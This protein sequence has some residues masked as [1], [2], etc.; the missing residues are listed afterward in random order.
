MKR[1]FKYIAVALAMSLLA[2]G[3][4]PEVLVPEQDKLP[5]ASSLEVVIT[6]DQTTNFVTF[7]VKNAQGFV[8]MWIFGEDLIDGKANKKF[9]YVGNDIVLRIREAGVHKV[10]VKAYN[11]HGV[12]VGSK[13]ESY[14]LDN[15]Y[16]EL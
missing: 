1:F 2:I 14:Q 3:C 11:A 4:T 9:A 15:T 8:P 10:E 5:E 6:P 13:I 12:S 16:R 7:S